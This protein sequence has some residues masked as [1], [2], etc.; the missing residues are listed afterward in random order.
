MFGE[1]L[2]YSA[3]AIW[4]F[5]TSVYL[6]SMLLKDFSIVDVAWG[7]GFIIV[8]AVSGWFATN[9]LMIQLL[10]GGLVLLWGVR[11]ALYIAYRK[12]GKDEDWRYKQWR[13]DWGQ[14][15]WWRSYLQVF[16]LQGLVMLIVALPIIMINATPTN[17]LEGY[18]IVGLVVW[19]VGY[20]FEVVGDMQ[21]LAFKSDSENKGK[22]MTTGLWKYT[23]HPN[24]FGE[25]VMWWGIFI[26]ALE[27]LNGFYT[28]V[29]PLLLTFLLLRVSGVKKLESKYKNN[30]DYQKYIKHTSSFIPWKKL[31]GK[32]VEVTVS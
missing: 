32:R 29:S 23:R 5:M 17:R 12:R 24:Y 8:C 7:L 15:A 18:Y 6:L 1:L 2:L 26:I 19:M 10:V 16:M 25:A 9:I 4:L 28:I 27:S 22:I 21:M 30:K 13:E 3:L 14:N 11:L 31:S 20:F